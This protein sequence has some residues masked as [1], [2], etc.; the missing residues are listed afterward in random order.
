MQGAPNFVINLVA[1]SRD[2][3]IAS[4]RLVLALAGIAAVYLGTGEPRAGSFVVYGLLGL[5][6]ALALFC[7]L[8]VKRT[9]NGERYMPSIS[10][11]PH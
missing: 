11:K 5:Y 8:M 1:I 2:R 4:T 6:I 7:L 10:Q 9:L 3:L